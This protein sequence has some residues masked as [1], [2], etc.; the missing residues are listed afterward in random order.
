M[1]TRIFLAAAIVPAL[2][3]FACSKPNE[4]SSA[5]ACDAAAAS[6]P[7]ASAAALP[8]AASEEPAAPSGT[9]SARPQLAKCAGL[10]CTDRDD[11]EPAA[12]AT[13][14]AVPPVEPMPQA[15]PDPVAPPPELAPLAPGLAA[16]LERVSATGEAIFVVQADVAAIAPADAVRAAATE[17]LAALRQEIPGNPACIVEIVASVKAFTYAWMESDT[18]PDVGIAI[19]ESGADL[20]GIFECVAQIDPSAIPAEARAAAGS[21]FVVLEPEEAAIASIGPGLLAIGS[22][23]AVRAARAGDVSN[24]LSSDPRL[25]SARAAAGPGPGWAAFLVHDAGESPQEDESFDGAVALR[26][27]PRVGVVGSFSFARVEM[28]GDV[29]DEVFEALGEIGDGRSEVLDVIGAAGLDAPIREKVLMM[30]DAV[31]GARIV[32]EGRRLSFEAWLP[33]GQSLAGLLTAAVR[34]LPVI[35]RM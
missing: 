35:T 7:E 27:S 12:P 23:A 25:Q 20:P 22:E 5:C 18:G 2:A 30:F 8:S 9:A 26:S 34:L 31:L 19:V 4:P 6:C 11:V 1:T 33:E 13:A 28:V 24:P 17:A 14:A 29:L 15:P 21:G 16:Q 32:A 10:G 3:V